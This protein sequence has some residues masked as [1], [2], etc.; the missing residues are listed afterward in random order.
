MGE[1]FG[2]YSSWGIVFVVYGRSILCFFLSVALDEKGG[3]E[4]VKSEIRS[5]KFLGFRVVNGVCFAR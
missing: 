2:S 1:R 5:I 3:G 4:R